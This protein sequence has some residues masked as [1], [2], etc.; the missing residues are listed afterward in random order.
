MAFTP[1]AGKHAVA[2]IEGT[3]DIA[4]P[5][6]D[7][8]LDPNPNSQEVDNFRD[9][10]ATMVTLEVATLN[11]TLIWDSDKPIHLSANGT[12]KNG[13]SITVNLYLDAAK[14]AN[15]GI[16]FAGVVTGWKLT[17]PG[18]KEKVML[19]TTARGTITYPTN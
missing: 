19:R 17:N 18:M 16:V 1:V 11:L 3:P 14:T 13:T 5:G 2:E 10:V 8:E 12:V 4:I 9:G 15:K 7:W 6:T